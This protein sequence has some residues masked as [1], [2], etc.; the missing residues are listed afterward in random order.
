M[1]VPGA[2]VPHF[3]VQC[4]DYPCVKS[5]PTEALSINSETGAVQV[6]EAKCTGC[7]VCINA[8]PGKVPHLHPGKERI[9]ICDLC[10]GKP[11]CVKICQEGKW[12]ALNAIKRVGWG[13]S[14]R[15]YCRTPEEITRELVINLYGEKGEELL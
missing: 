8:C 5:C 3:C 2:E 9:L 11:E 15:A 6:D 13:E 4:E 7:G 14:L 1:L 10:G 12:N